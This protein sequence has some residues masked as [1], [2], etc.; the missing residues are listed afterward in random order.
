MYSVK[1]N[2][3]AH[4][5]WLIWLP[6]ILGFLY[7]RMCFN[8]IVN[9]LD[10]MDANIKK[11]ILLHPN[12]HFDCTV[13]LGKQVSFQ[14]AH[15]LHILSAENK[16]SLRVEGICIEKTHVFVTYE[17]AH[18]EP[19]PKGIAPWITL[20]TRLERSSL[21]S[22]GFNK[23]KKDNVRVVRGMINIVDAD[24]QVDR[25]RCD[26]TVRKNCREIIETFG[27]QMMDEACVRMVL[28]GT[29]NIC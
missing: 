12:A 10:H 6:G 9:N 18:S 3:K 2:N 14:E 4:R 16:K 20:L 27:L 24:F 29:R 13:E 23:L 19:V 25:K 17:K 22:I 21:G 5:R 15:I 28:Q 1:G 26:S 11:Y 8:G 7:F